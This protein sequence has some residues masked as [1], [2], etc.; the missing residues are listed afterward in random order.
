MTYLEILKEDRYYASYLDFRRDILKNYLPG[1]P[2]IV[3]KVTF[4]NTQVFILF[5]R[6]CGY[7]LPGLV[8]PPVTH[9]LCCV[10][11]SVQHMLLLCD[12]SGLKF[13]VL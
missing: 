11:L 13:G 9:L 3:S 6:R 8:A 1:Y 4:P 2:V 10:S 7:Y 5:S 12:L